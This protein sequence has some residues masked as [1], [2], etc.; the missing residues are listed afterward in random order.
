MTDGPTLTVLVLGGTTEGR[1]LAAALDGRPG[2]R[3]VSS[4]AG[5]T[6]NPLPVAGETRSGGFGG[7]DGL[8]GWLDEHRPVVLVDATHPYAV[9][10]SA[11]AAQATRSTGTPMLRLTRP[12][13]VEQ[14]GDRWQRV[15]SAEHAAV[16]VA[17]LGE[18]PLLTTGHAGLTSF[19]T[20]CAHLPALLRSV[21]PPSL[22]LPGPWR[23]LLARGPFEL[24]AERA[25]LAEHRADV[26]V[27][28]DSGG[29]GAKL[30]AAR[31]AG[32]PV[33]LI[34]RPIPGVVV[35]RPGLHRAPEPREVSSLD[36]AVDWVLACLR[37]R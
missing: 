26:L 8:E 14:P 17:A 23:L 36:Q 16:L 18:R 9:V 31:E 27:T 24:G 33:V 29:D 5:R 15:P 25:L 20:A 19:T 37:H 3:V 6:G 10:M 21:E 7:F 22:T 13:W 12:G 28:R 30:T 11:T 35:T 4:L 34:D 32:L 1:E 2:L